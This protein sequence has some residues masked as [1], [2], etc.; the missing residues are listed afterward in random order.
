VDEERLEAAMDDSNLGPYHGQYDGHSKLYLILSFC[1]SGLALAAVFFALRFGVPSSSHLSGTANIVV[2]CSF[3][4]IVLVFHLNSLSLF[5]RLSA[6]IRNGDGNAEFLDRT[7][8]GIASMTLGFSLAIMI[9]AT[10]LLI[11]GFGR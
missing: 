5:K 3:A 7:R 6:Q 10:Q 4:V 1:M 9:L 11:H 2:I 8:L